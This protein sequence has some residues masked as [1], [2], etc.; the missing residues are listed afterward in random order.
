[1]ILKPITYTLIGAMLAGGCATGYNPQTQ[2][3]HERIAAIPNQPTPESTIC[4]KVLYNKIDVNQSKEMIAEQMQIKRSCG[5]DLINN[6]KTLYTLE[7]GQAKE[8]TRSV[9]RQVSRDA[10]SRN[11]FNYE[12]AFFAALS[13]WT[14]QG[15]SISELAGR[16]FG[17]NFK[18]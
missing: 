12:E 1:M 10:G 14:H 15:N 18:K 4:D 2:T 8:W 6:F 7:Y 13:M 16:S 5:Q 3:R 11:G 9:E 17:T